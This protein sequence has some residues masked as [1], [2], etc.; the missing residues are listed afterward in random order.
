MDDNQSWTLVIPRTPPSANVLL[1]YHWSQRAKLIDEWCHDI[2]A[3][4][5]LAHMEPMERA[6]IDC[7]VY[8]PT[9]RT[10]DI[11]NVLLALDKLCADALVRLG[12]LPD[13]SPAHLSWSI[14]VL[15][16]DPVNPR[17]EVTLKDV[18]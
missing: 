12:Y 7:T 11:P 15:D 13:D 4:A 2:W 9:R 1:R 6:T 8:Y 14:P 18:T 3:L 10:R 5:N 16:T 17:T